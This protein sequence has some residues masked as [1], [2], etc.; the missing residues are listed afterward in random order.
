MEELLSAFT[1]VYVSF[2]GNRRYEVDVFPRF[3]GEEH[4]R[5][6]PL[7]VSGEELKECLE[8]LGVNSINTYPLDRPR[9]SVAVP[10]PLDDIV[11]RVRELGNSLTLVAADVDGDSM[12]QRIDEWRKRHPDTGR[13]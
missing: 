6:A 4:T 1:R 5:H 9:V 7:F 12:R 10:V 11:R 3:S 13:S 8:A 2:I